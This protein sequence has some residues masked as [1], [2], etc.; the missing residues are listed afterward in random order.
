MSEVTSHSSPAARYSF[1]TL[2]L[3]YCVHLLTTSSQKKGQ[4]VNRLC[5][6]LCR[7]SEALPLLNFPPGLP[8]VFRTK[9][10]LDPKL[11]EAWPQLTECTAALCCSPP[12]ALWS[13]GHTEFFTW[14]V[15]I[16]PKPFH[17]G[18]LPP[19]PSLSGSVQ[20]PPSRGQHPS[21][22]SLGDVSLLAWVKLYTLQQLSVLLFPSPTYMVCFRGKSCVFSSLCAH[23]IK[24]CL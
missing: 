13:V 5:H 21:F 20:S 17:S 24:Q 23:T 18:S 14:A 1:M 15:S 11:S 4:H 8:V 16:L 22:Q 6:S 7:Q 12:P 2:W 10:N 19:A 3:P 9:S